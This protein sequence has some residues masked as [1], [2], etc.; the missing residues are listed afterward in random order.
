MNI[1][2]SKNINLHSKSTDGGLVHIN[3]GQKKRVPD[4]VV[5]HPGFKILVNAGVVTILKST[6]MLPLADALMKKNPFEPEV[7]VPANV[8]PSGTVIVDNKG[9]PVS[10][11][12]G[13]KLVPIDLDAEPILAEGEVEEDEDTPGEIEETEEK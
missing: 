5:D 11:S 13:K 7:E 4:D 8:P 2:A 9:K 6:K 1:L 3:A 12:D 10:I